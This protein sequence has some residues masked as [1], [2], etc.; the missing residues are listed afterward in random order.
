MAS[1]WQLVTP[2]HDTSRCLWHSWCSRISHCIVSNTAQPLRL[3]YRR[4]ANPCLPQHRSHTTASTAF[5]E[6]RQPWI[7]METARYGRSMCSVKATKPIVGLLPTQ[8][9]IRLCAALAQPQ[10]AERCTMWFAALHDPKQT[11][12][13]QLVSENVRMTD[14]SVDAC[15]SGQAALRHR[16]EVCQCALMLSLIHLGRCRRIRRLMNRWAG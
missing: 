1:I 14:H 5:R 11:S 3:R 2:C 7:L 16:L 9:A 13:E 6:R 4:P 15:Y 10:L 12:I 8:R